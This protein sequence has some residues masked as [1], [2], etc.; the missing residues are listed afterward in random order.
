MRP[1]AIAS[2]MLL[3]PGYRNLDDRKVCERFYH[4]GWTAARLAESEGVMYLRQSPDY[5]TH[6]TLW[7]NDVI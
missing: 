1:K 2:G 7:V 4:G 6:L 5:G 3:P